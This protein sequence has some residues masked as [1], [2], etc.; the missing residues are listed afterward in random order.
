MPILEY[1]DS[2]PLLPTIA[3]DPFDA[4]ADPRRRRILELLAEEERPVNEVVEAMDMS[5]PQVSKH[6][7]AL[8]EVGL[9]TVRGDGR[10]RLYSLNAAR[11]KPAYDWIGTFEPFWRQQLERIKDRAEQAATSPHAPRDHS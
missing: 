4:L 6:L 11:L 7:R 5:Q 8:R 2:V 10:R 1:I 3:A 9:V